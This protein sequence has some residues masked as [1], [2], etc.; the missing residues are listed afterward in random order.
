MIIRGM[1]T[2]QM[3][4]HIRTCQVTLIDFLFFFKV[5]QTPLGKKDGKGW[6]QICR[7]HLV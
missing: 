1:L 7:L 6:V 2:T 4:G 3:D 5:L